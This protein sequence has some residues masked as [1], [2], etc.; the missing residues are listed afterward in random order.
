MSEGEEED[1]TDSLAL[2][3]HTCMGDIVLR[4]NIDQSRV[5]D[6]GNKQT[7]KKG[8][9]VPGPLDRQ[10]RSAVMHSQ[11]SSQPLPHY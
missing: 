5:M 10:L 3:R 7:K 4:L 2:G 11:N 6:H 9:R 8:V 1:E